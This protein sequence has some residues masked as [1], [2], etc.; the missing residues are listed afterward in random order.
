MLVN[1][2]LHEWEIGE[3][4]AVIE[5]LVRILH[6]CKGGAELVDEFNQRLVRR[7]EMTFTKGHL[8]SGYVDRFRLVP[9]FG[10]DCIRVFRS[11]VADLK[12][13]AARDYEDILQVRL[14]C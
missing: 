12:G 5:H 13:L 11:N 4:K 7:Y 9:P 8:M 3:A 10:R 2:W 6:S 14:L 1:D